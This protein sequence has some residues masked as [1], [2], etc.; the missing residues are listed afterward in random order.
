MVLV[1]NQPTPIIAPV[2][3]TARTKRARSRGR[4]TRRAMTSS[5]IWTPL[6]PNG[7]AS[8]VAVTGR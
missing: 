5:L 7:W 6:V 1:A 3:A 2:I 4:R 8:G